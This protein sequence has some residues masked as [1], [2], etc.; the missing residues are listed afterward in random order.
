MS[1]L[2]EKYKII[3]N[4][5]LDRIVKNKKKQSFKLH[6]RV[7]TPSHDGE[8]SIEL[9]AGMEMC[10]TDLQ[11]LSNNFIINSDNLAYINEIGLILINCEVNNA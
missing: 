10:E 8:K 2:S 11:Y 9:V 3:E 5:K 6:F 1:N 7:E 4:A